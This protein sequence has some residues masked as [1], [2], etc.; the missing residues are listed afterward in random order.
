MASRININ[1]ARL[2]QYHEDLMDEIY[3]L[4][5]TYPLNFPNYALTREELAQM[6]E[7]D[8]MGRNL[9]SGLGGGRS[10]GHKCTVFH[11][12]PDFCNGLPRKGR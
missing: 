10:A 6:S 5:H 8:A 11:R 4:H 12:D 7:H 3:L 9:S 2:L 1:E